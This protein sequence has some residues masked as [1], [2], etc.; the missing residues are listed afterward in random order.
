LWLQDAAQRRLWL[1]SEWAKINKNAS[2]L[3]RFPLFLFPGLPSA[4]LYEGAP[5]IQ[6]AHPGSYEQ[7]P[8]VDCYRLPEQ[9]RQQLITEVQQQRQENSADEVASSGAKNV[10]GLENGTAF[11]LNSLHFIVFFPEAPSFTTTSSVNGRSAGCCCGNNVVKKF[12]QTVIYPST[13]LN[14]KYFGGKRP[15][16]SQQ[17]QQQQ[18]PGKAVG[19]DGG[20][21][22][23]KALDSGFC[24]G[25]SGLAFCSG[26]SGGLAGSPP[27]G[28][29]MLG[30]F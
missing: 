23:K 3:I 10:S 17:H 28:S 18:Q 30:S 14:G 6:L 5:T 24:S 29:F 21:G 15:A 25:S 2:Q 12:G 22:G 7:D 9:P 4:V 19:S 27:G 1:R 13:A 16:S 11:P 8:V 26:G 20:G